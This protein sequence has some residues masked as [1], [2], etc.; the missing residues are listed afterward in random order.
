MKK[1]DDRDDGESMKAKL[2]MTL[3]NKKGY[4]RVRKIITVRKD[5]GKDSKQ[6]MTFLEPADVKETSF[7]S[8]VYDDPK[9]DDLQWLYLPAF[10]RVRKISSSSKKESFMGSDFNYEDLG[11]RDLDADVHKLVKEEK[12]NNRDCYVI[13]SVPK[14]KRYMYSKRVGWIDKES[15]L[16]VKVDYYDRRGRHIKQL[17]CSGI[18]KIDNIWT[19]TS[20]KMENIKKKHSTVLE[21][22]DVKYNQKISDDFFTERYLKRGL[23]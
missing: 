21:F 6:M 13:E 9:K 15:L 7:L 12:F 3:T 20:I 16:P 4:E 23:E 1:V 10:E 2:T 19:W 14:N 11:D 8:W 5:F 17:T 22:S 18:E